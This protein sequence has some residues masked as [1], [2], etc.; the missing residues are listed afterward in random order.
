MV[1][2]PLAQPAGEVV[3]RPAVVAQ[4]DRVRRRDDLLEQVRDGAV[5]QAVV[6][7]SAAQVGRALIMPN[8]RPPVTT[9]RQ[10]LDY[11]QRILDAVP[12]G[13]AFDP[14]MSLYLT[15]QTPP[16]EIALAA[17][18]NTSRKRRYSGG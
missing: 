17:A 18:E 9:A 14:V 6:P 8:L 10:A 3:A 15:D 16:E 7:H 12:A 1:R 2:C 11:R 5:L 13:T 4:D